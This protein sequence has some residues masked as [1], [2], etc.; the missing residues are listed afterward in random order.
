MRNDV[1]LKLQR[2]IEGNDRITWDLFPAIYDGFLE[3]DEL[4][5]AED[6][7][8]QFVASTVQRCSDDKILSTAS[9]EKIAEYESEFG[10]SADR[11]TLE[12]RRQQVIGYINRSRVFNETTLHELCQ[13]LAGDKTVYERVDFHYL[14]LGVFT[15]D[16][17]DG[18][19]PAVGIVDQIRPAVPQNLALYAGTE[20]HFERVAVVNHANFC[21]LKAGLGI[22][23]WHEPPIP[24]PPEN[25]PDF[26]VLDV[27]TGEVVHTADVGQVGYIPFTQMYQIESV[28]HLGYIPFTQLFKLPNDTL[29]YIENPPVQG[30]IGYMYRDSNV[31][32]TANN[33]DY[34][35][36]YD[37]DGTTVRTYDS[38]K[39][40]TLIHVLTDQNT[41]KDEYLEQLYIYGQYGILNLKARS[42]TYA[43]L[44]FWR[45]EYTEE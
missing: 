27:E 24:P 17:E 31:T 38:T 4:S 40:Y 8:L 2:I 30:I 26:A 1:I 39:T 45:V 35:Y 5:L 12:Q 43:T 6:R 21:A 16:A 14:T 29:K 42:G 37:S 9:E 20:T 41:Y 19:L 33:S 11:L 22:V 13:S 7:M 34:L 15:E 23:E 32:L 18:S 3:A 25:K 10:L 44:T 36:V 28:A